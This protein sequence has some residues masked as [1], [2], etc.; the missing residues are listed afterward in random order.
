MCARYAIYVKK[1]THLN[2]YFKP[3]AY[4]GHPAK[5]YQCW[6]L[7]SVKRDESVH[8]LPLNAK[9]NRNARHKIALIY[10]CSETKYFV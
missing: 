3:V 5:Q 7:I 8:E 10:L 1:Y 6:S 4:S 2:I 9:E